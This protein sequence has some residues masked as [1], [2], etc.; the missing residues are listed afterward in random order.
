[1][2]ALATSLALL[3]F[4]FTAAA[5]TATPVTVAATIDAGDE[6]AGLVPVRVTITNT[7]P[8]PVLA[9]IYVLIRNNPYGTTLL[10]STG[11]TRVTVA[12]QSTATHDF[13]IAFPQR[14]GRALVDI[15]VVWREAT[16]IGGELVFDRQ[17]TFTMFRRF[18]VTTAADDGAGSLRATI[19][20]VNANP[21]CATLPCRIEFAI[22]AAMGTS[23]IRVHTPLPVITARDIEVDASTQSNTNLAGP[24]V[25]LLGSALTT[26]DGLEIRAANTLV[27]GF[28]IGGFPGSG[29]MF[30]PAVFGSAFVFERNFIG[31]DPTG[32]HALPNG[33]RGITIDGGVVSN[34][35][36]RDNVISGNG[37][38]GIY[39]ETSRNQFGPLSPVVRITGNRIG[40]AA[41]SD[42]PIGN[43]ASGIYTG[44]TSEWVRV[45]NNVIAHNAHMGVA[46]A[47]GGFSH[48]VI[49]NRIHRNGGQAIDW[50]LN[51]PSVVQFFS[52]G[53]GAIL[54]S[55]TYDA[56]TNTTVIR[57]RTITGLTGFPTFINFYAS[58]ELDAGGAAP[59]EEFLGEIQVMS[60]QPFEVRLPG[61]HRGRYIAATERAW[62]D[63][64]W[65]E[66]SEL[67]AP[68]RVQ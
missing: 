53:L 41:A 32:T 20:T 58:D 62:V 12:A 23:T 67:S 63:L 52:R 55:A 31:V 64:A 43:G 5:Q 18:T 50:G 49:A 14:A 40:V 8:R 1:M 54:E 59:M 48:V 45:D 28:S 68:V 60:D 65:T 11:E 66:T 46:H 35:I 27:R 36:I 24:D 2:K 13:A 9:D 6:S 47:T 16:G 19:D 61:D 3:L 21:E 10:G 56:A 17:F 51:G 44:P 30:R 25:E 22:P 26:G 29:I 15:R 37:R 57:G 34:S 4:A 39:I 42:S 38:S 33:T 7:L